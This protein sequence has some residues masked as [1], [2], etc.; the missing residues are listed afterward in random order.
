VI[1][2]LRAT[3]GDDAVRAQDALALLTGLLAERGSRP[4]AA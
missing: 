1:E 3:V 2:E 4:V